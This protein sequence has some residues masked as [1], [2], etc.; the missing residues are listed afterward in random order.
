MSFLADES[1]NFPIVRSL[2]D[3]NYNVDYIAEIN[4]G[5]SDDQVIDLAHQNNR[6][7]ITAD[8]DFGEYIHISN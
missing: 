7:L 3:N 2:R 6:I 8:K 1:V 4:P 5:I